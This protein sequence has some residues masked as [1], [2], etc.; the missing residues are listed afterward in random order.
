MTRTASEQAPVRLALN[1]ASA[2]I[3]WTVHG[4]GKSALLHRNGEMSQVIGQTASA[5][6]N[7]LQTHYEAATVTGPLR[8]PV[9]GSHHTAALTAIT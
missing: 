9:P 8:H 5:A 3:E 7:V 2:W 1:A 4:A 6:E